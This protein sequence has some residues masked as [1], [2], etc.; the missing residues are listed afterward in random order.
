MIPNGKGKEIW[1]MSARL[2][3]CSMCAETGFEKAQDQLEKHRWNRQ[4]AADRVI[5]S[6]IG[7]VQWNTSLRPCGASSG[8]ASCV[9]TCAGGSGEIVFL[10]GDFYRFPAGTC[11]VSRTTTRTRTS[12]AHQLLAM[13]TVHI[14]PYTTADQQCFWQSTVWTNYWLK[15]L[16]ASDCNCLASW[17]LALGGG[18]SWCLRPETRQGKR[19]RLPGIFWAKWVARTPKNYSTSYP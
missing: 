10:G 11:K 3:R 19:S 8:R 18:I 17:C 5:C 16:V 7:T 13:A 9:H 4:T 12:R 2:I 15:L 1:L 14:S 6:T